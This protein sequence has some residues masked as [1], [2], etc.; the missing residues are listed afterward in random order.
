MRALEP[1]VFDAVPAA[2]MDFEVSD[3]TLRARRDEWMESRSGG[4]GIT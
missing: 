4:E 2:F 3:T 1:E